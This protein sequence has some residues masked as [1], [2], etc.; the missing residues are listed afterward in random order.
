MA[1]TPEFV[2]LLTQAGWTQIGSDGL[3]LLNDAGLVTEFSAYED[4]DTL[5]GDIYTGKRGEKQRIY[6]CFFPLERTAE[7][8]AL[9]DQGA[10]AMT[11]DDPDGWLREL[12]M[13][14][15]YVAWQKSTRDR[16]VFPRS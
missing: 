3:E 4:E 1:E 7:I 11:A 5:V 2:N 16:I 12:A 15:V 9:I 8:L 6:G 13:C 14:D 10:R